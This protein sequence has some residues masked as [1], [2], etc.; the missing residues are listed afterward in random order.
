MKRLIII[1]MT[2]AATVFTLAA[3]NMETENGST[4]GAVETEPDPIPTQE[5]QPAE[6]DVQTQE[7]RYGNTSGNISNGAFAA[8]DGENIYYMLPT[9]LEYEVS[10]GNLIKTDPDNSIKT[11]LLS[12][13][14]PY[15]LNVVDGWIYY[16]SSPEKRIYKIREDGTGNELITT[17]ETLDGFM[18]G[19]AAEN[20]SGIY[21]M[22]VADDWIYCR[23]NNSDNTK[24][25]YRINTDDGEMEKLLQIDGLMHGFA[26]HAGWIY[27]SSNENDAWE[28][29]RMRTDGSENT[30]IA[31]VPLSSLNIENEK[32]YYIGGDTGM[33]IYS[34]DLDGANNER[35]A[36]GI[37]AVCINVAGDWIYYATGA[38]IC[39]VQTDGTG[40]TKLVDFSSTSY[41]GLNVV[42][43][44]IYLQ[45][46]QDLGGGQIIHRM[47]TDGSGLQEVTSMK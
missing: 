46:G 14:R 47:K 41:I 11:V 32:I 18:Q 44:W 16:V 5:T 38:E 25:I 4:S 7:T 33:Q 22:A 8:Q 21:R 29:F 39:K 23:V 40:K 10:M 15:C 35:I 34:M 24:E 9:H 26:V 30:K 36:D 3:C 43:D 27:Y 2:V 42:N 6:E 45:D 20:L 13:E 1:A 17:S 12:G 31:E 19:Y 37:T 28:A